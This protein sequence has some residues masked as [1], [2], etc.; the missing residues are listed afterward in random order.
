MLE[1]QSGASRQEN[2]VF[3]RLESKVQSYARIL[4]AHLQPRTR[5]RI[6]GRA[7]RPLSRLPRRRRV[8][9]LRPQQPRLQGGAD[10]IHRGG[11]DHPQ[12]RPAHRGQ[13]EF[14]EAMQDIMLAPRGLDYVIQFTGPTGTNAVEAALKLARKVTGRTNV[15][16]FTNGFH[17]VSMGALAVTGNEYLRRAA[18]V[19]LHGR[20]PDAVRRLLRRGR[21]H[22]RL[23][24]AHARRP[25]RAAWTRRPR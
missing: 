25:A 4:P 15:I 9:E 16:Y 1:R 21:R 17:G 11:R 5:H 24:R 13:G 14:L 10:R 8:A 20:D 23:S 7:R 22:H 12:P 18:G 19:P 6:V 2:E 3:G